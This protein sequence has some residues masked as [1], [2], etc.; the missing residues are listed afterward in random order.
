[1]RTLN[2][3]EKVKRSEELTPEEIA[4][5]VN[6]FTKGDIP[7]YQMSAFLMAVCLR[8]LSRSA[9]KTL[10]A[11]MRDSGDKVDLSEFG[12]LTVDKHSTGGVGDKTTLILIPIVSLLGAKIAKMSGRGL[13]FTGGTVDKLESIP[14]YKTVLSPEEFISQVRSVGAA[15]IG[16]SGML[17]PADKKMYAL[18]DVT[19]TVDSLPLIASSIMSK[20][21]AAGSASIVLDVKCGS[22]SFMKTPEDAAALAREM[23]QI[24][25]DCGRN[26]SAFITDMDTPLG[27]NI[28][29]ALEVKEAVAVLCGG[30]PADLREVCVTLAAEMLRLATDIPSEQAREAVLTSISDG[31]AFNQ[32]K[33][34]VAAQGGDTRVLDDTSLLPEAEHEYILNARESGYITHTDAALIGKA[35]VMLGAGRERKDDTIDPGAGIILMKKRGDSVTAGEPVAKLRAADTAMFAEP[36]QM[37]TD[38][39]SIGNSAPEKQKLIIGHI[40]K[41]DL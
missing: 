24:G 7:D 26:V 18:R 13:G 19:A 39:I 21:L 17:T 3:I 41:E 16:Q 1:M 38:A 4:F 27:E 36:A 30:G 9:V 32:M 23:V 31:S 37:L 40:G 14:G 29:N 12:K 28:G 20:K 11:V 8:G 22:G 33:K 35:S 5:I 10:T 15:V 34:W 6:G 25:T 2:I